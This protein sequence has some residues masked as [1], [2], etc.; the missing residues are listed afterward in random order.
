MQKNWK[1][2]GII[3]EKFDTQAAFAKH[4]GMNASIVCSVISGRY[5][6]NA[7]EMAAWN[8]ALGTTNLE[9]YLD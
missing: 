9:F 8:E 4:I 5:R 1:L 2:A 3:G 6:L 7:D